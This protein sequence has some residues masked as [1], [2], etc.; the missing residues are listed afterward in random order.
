MKV[1]DSVYDKHGHELFFKDLET[2]LRHKEPVY[3]KDGDE[4]CF[5][6]EGNAN[7]LSKGFIDILGSARV[8]FCPYCYAC[9]QEFF[10][11]QIQKPQC[12]V[13]G[14]LPNSIL[15]NHDKVCEYFEIDSRKRDYET[16]KKQIDEQR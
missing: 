7:I 16:V 15:F 2:L 13:Y 10:D 4:L 6:E 11:T 3:N 12:R 8:V 9:K 5:D 1:K 14:T